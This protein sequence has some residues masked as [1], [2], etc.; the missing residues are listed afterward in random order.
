[1]GWERRGVAAAFATTVSVVVVQGLGT[2]QSAWFGPPIAGAAGPLLLPIVAAGVAHWRKPT[3]VVAGLTSLVVGGGLALFGSLAWAYLPV[4]LLVALMLAALAQRIA[5]SIAPS[6]DGAWHRSARKTI[7]W[8]ALALLMV[9]QVSRLGAFMTDRD[10]TWGSTFPPVEFTVTHM[11]MASYVHAADLARRGAPNIYSPEHY[12]AFHVR[13]AEHI[14]TDVVGLQQYFDDAFLYAPAFLLLPRAWLALSNDYLTIRAVWF[15]VQ[16][17]A[18]FIFAIFLGRWVGGPG[19]AW[20]LWLL[21]LVLASMPTMFNFQFGQAHLLTIWTAMAAMVAFDQKRPALGG[22]L[23]AWGV[24]S[25]I[26][27]GVLLFYLLVQRRWRDVLWTAGF[28]VTLVLL[29]I[30]VTGTKPATAFTMYMLPR[31]VSGDAFSFITDTLPIVTN[32]SIPGTVW[33]LQF[34]GLEGASSLLRVVSAIYTVCLLALVW[35]GAGREG[36]RLVRAQ[37]WLAILI[38]AS[39]RSPIVPIYGAAPILWLMALE[40]DRVRTTVGLI[41]FGISWVFINGLPPA[42]NPVVTVALFGVA[43]IV[44]LYWVLRP[45]GAASRSA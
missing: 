41:F 6:V 7:G 15:A 31:L 32:L 24:A 21:P 42:P 13:E 17:L 12:P 3:A 44:M 34:L 39:L 11:C 23:L 45:L 26:F 27:P 36:N 38:L 29:A 19:G 10:N 43:Q 1:M 14:E 33:K 28:T 40:V 35:I 9:L 2:L 18:F 8:T 20:S 4:A 5:D 25:K 37:I 22:A 30:V 16:F